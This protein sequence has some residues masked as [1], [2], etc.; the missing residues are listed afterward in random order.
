LTSATIVALGDSTTAGT[1]GFQSPIEAPPG[2]A[3][4]VESQYAYWLMRVHREWRVLNH[5]V[6]GERSDQIR[7]RFE[8]DVIGLAI[9]LVVLIAGVNDI[10]QNHSAQHVQQEL[11]AIF[12]LATR[13]KRPIPVVAGSILPFNTATAE[14]NRRMI[15][16]NQWIRDYVAGHA[17]LDFCDTRAACADPRD[18]DRLASSPDNLHPSPDGY[19]LVAIALEPVI[20]RVLERERRPGE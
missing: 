5:G 15:A 17:H 9:D 1:P 14:Q 16:V 18:P 11:E 8:R 6:N 20:R 10:Y 19:R 13:A 4:N 12:N 2:G 7:R 3:G